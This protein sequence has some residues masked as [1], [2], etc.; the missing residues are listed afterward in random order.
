M[1]AH[2]IVGPLLYL[3]VCDF[4]LC[5]LGAS[6]ANNCP[7]GQAGWQRI[8]T[9]IVTDQNDHDIKNTDQHLA[10]SLTMGNN[11]LALVLNIS[12]AVTDFSG[13]FTDKFNFCSSV[14][15]TSPSATTS[16]TQ[17]IADTFNGSNYKLKDTAFVYACGYITINGS[18]LP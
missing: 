5:L 13:Q 14:C 10:E 15:K 4:N 9:R 1:C 18:R 11:G 8:T 2:V 6:M 17:H 7:A 12:P 3:R 16:F